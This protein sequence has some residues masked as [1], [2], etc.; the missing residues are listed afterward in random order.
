MKWYRLASGTGLQPPERQ[1]ELD[2]SSYES[3]I[4][5]LRGLPREQVAAMQEQ[6]VQLR[7]EHFSPNPG[8]IKLYH[9]TPTSNAEKI[10]QGGLEVGEG[11]RS[12]FM[13]SEKTV[14][15]QG[16]FLTDDKALAHYFG[17]NRADHPADY[18]VLT[19]YVDSSDVMDFES[20]PRELVR[21]GLRIVNEY[22]G[23]KKTRLAIR[24]WWWLLDRPEFVEATRQH[25]Y[26]GVRFRES[27]AINRAAGS[28]GGNT[29]LM[30][31]PSGIKI[32]GREGIRTI[33]DYYEWLVAGGN[34]P[35][36]GQA[37]LSHAAPISS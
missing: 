15:N 4:G 31:D 32:E 27:T 9:G 21:L 3:F 18:E 24:D 37:Y 29:Y 10:M 7:D 23:T 19:C 26:S 6:L 5:S 1:S 30:F 20:A 16:V 12:G 33:R 17:S 8:W 36:R 28:A 13:G 14:M 11:R 2:L 22:E 34:P 25:G 35:D